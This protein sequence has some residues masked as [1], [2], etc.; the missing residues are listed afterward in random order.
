MRARRVL[1]LCGSGLL[2]RGVQSLLETDPRVEI[3]G[4]TGDLGQANALIQELLPDVLLVDESECPT[5]FGPASSGVTLAP[6]PLVITLRE[7]DN[8][9]RVYRM[10]ERVLTD[11]GELIER[12]LA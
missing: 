5:F 11:F 8:L 9:I 10:E 7:S 6:V 12:L 1:L 3:V 4:S 2:G